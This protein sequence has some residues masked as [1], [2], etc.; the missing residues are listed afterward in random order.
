MCC[1]KKKEARGSFGAVVIPQVED[2]LDKYISLLGLLSRN[3][4]AA[5]QEMAPAAEKMTFEQAEALMKE[6]QRGQWG[7]YRGLA[8]EARKSFTILKDGFD[9]KPRKHINLLKRVCRKF[10]DGRA[11]VNTFP[12]VL[13]KKPDARSESE[14]KVVQ[15]LQDVLDQRI[16]SLEAQLGEDG[17]ATLASQ[18]QLESCVSDV[19]EIVEE[20]IQQRAHKQNKLT[21][22][23]NVFL[24][25][26]NGTFE[27]LRDG[28]WTSPEVPKPLMAGL[29]KLFKQVEMDAPTAKTLTGVLKKKPDDRGTFDKILV[30]Q[31]EETV[32][33]RLATFDE[34]VVPADT[35]GRYGA[36]KEAAET[37]EQIQEELETA[38]E[39]QQTRL[40]AALGSE[41]ER[42]RLELAVEHKMSSMNEKVEEEKQAAI[43]HADKQAT[44][45][46][47]QKARDNLAFLRERSEGGGA[48]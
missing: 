30:A 14:G 16:A 35:V 23:K 42:R 47:F 36:V 19:Q 41:N 11:L 4:A 12:K 8:I 40:E 43:D 38:R 18:Q 24:E 2:C 3:V 22:E 21:K 7:E 10:P 44:L 39:Q 48:P 6:V 5:V 28:S 37:V 15:K 25:L 20:E 45:E 13:E 1:R 26:K 29:K 27:P 17:L 32:R 34:N 9:G 33:K 46:T 31:F